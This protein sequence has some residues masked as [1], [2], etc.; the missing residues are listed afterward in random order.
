MSNKVGGLL[1]VLEKDIYAED[2]ESIKKALLLIKGVIEV[3]PVNGGGGFTETCAT[4]KEKARIR[5][6]LVDLIHTL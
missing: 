2:F 4:N 6:K 1:V 5:D 3:T